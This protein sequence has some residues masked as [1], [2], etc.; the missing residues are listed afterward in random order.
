MELV[1]TLTRPKAKGPEWDE[2]SQTFLVAPII[3]ANDDFYKN[4]GLA[5]DGIG[6]KNEWFLQ[7]GNP[8]KVRTGISLLDYSADDFSVITNNADLEVLEVE[9]IEGELVLTVEST[10]VVKIKA[11]DFLFNLSTDRTIQPVKEEEEVT[12]DDLDDEEDSEF[13][14]SNLEIEED[15]DED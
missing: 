15:E 2:A 12:L 9:L 8:M 14:F 11:G 3:H 6:F 1:Y 13:D 4:Q 5:W 7:P 10:E